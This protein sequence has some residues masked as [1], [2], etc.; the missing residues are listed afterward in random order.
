MFDFS[1]FKESPLMYGLAALIIGF[2]VVQSV[3]F[4]VKAW[5]RGKELGISN[6]KLKNTVISSAL[7]SVAPAISILATV[8]VLASALG[9]VLPWIRLS[10]IGNLLYETSA[11][12]TMLD[13][14]GS[15]INTEV[16]N[17]E[18][19][20]AVAWVMT[21]GI[22]LGL[23]LVTVFGRFILKKINKA[24]AKNEKNSNIADI[25]SASAFIGIIAAFVAQSI[26]G[27]SSDGSSDAG[28][29]SI[30]TLVSAVVIS[31][32]FETLCQKLRLK[33]LEIFA[34]PLSIFGAMAVAVILNM[35]LPA[36]ITSFTW[37]G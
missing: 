7:F 12:N 6:D 32:V 9:I 36:E 16:S 31:L 14:L 18:D 34:M 1:D 29:M 24:T 19:F 17:P 5:K 27:K 11:A 25:I 13:I 10:V 22:S 8:I 37:W 20:A 4:L 2:V 35:W 3:F 26:N 21:I 15:N 30:V 23:M 28:F 33:K